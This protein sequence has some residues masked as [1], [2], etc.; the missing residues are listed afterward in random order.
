[1]KV[2][3][4]RRT[5]LFFSEWSERNVIN[6]MHDRVGKQI[7]ARQV[8]KSEKSATCQHLLCSDRK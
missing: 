6:K 2:G 4:R 1:M 5:Q 3:R 7:I 8:V